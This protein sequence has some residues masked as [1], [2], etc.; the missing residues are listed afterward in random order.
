MSVGYSSTFIGQDR[1]KA[2]LAFAIG[3]DMPGY[4]LICDGPN[5]PSAGFTLVQDIL[6]SRRQRKANA[7]TSGVISIILKTSGLRKPY[8]LL[9]GEGRQFGQKNRSINR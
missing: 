9:P 7:L 6:Q 1:A 3:M 2:A 4:N 8:G 5:P